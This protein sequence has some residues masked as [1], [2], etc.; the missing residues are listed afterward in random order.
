MLRDVD[1]SLLI[2]HKFLSNATHKPTGK[3][4]KNFGDWIYLP[5]LN[6]L[7]TNAIVEDGC[8]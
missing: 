3:D 4:E 6:P 8:V 5:I 2:L 1:G 7:A